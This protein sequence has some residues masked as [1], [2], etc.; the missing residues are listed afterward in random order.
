MCLKF[1]VM[2]IF[3]L[4]LIL[5]SNFYFLNELCFIIV[6]KF[7]KLVNQFSNIFILMKIRNGIFKV[8]NAFLK[9]NFILLV[10]IDM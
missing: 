7:S 5:I 1:I 10:L 4:Q 8:I 2:F 9:V 3:A 6:I